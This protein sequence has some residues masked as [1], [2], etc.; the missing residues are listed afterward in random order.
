MRQKLHCSNSQTERG[1]GHKE[2]RKGR[3]LN[4]P[5]AS[6]STGCPQRKVTAKVQEKLLLQKKGRAEMSGGDRELGISVA[7]VQMPWP[8]GEAELGLR[9]YLPPCIF[10]T[11]GGRCAHGTASA[12]CL[13]HSCDTAPRRR[14]H[15]L[16]HPA[17]GSGSLVYPQSSWNR[18][19][20]G[21]T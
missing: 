3:P 8:K 19:S 20:A 18:A 16:T 7:H 1:V 17:Q 5:S 15:G 4:V 21:W 6:W 12:A 14:L 13:G 2:E 11:P 9:S 10:P